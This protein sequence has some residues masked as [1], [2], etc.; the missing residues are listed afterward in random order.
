MKELAEKDKAVKETMDKERLAA[1]KAADIL[2]F[3]LFGFGEVLVFLI[4]FMGPHCLAHSLY[5]FTPCHFTVFRAKLIFSTNEMSSSKDNSF[6]YH[7]KWLVIPFNHTFNN[8]KLRKPFY[9][10][11]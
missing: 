9:R 4:G 11:P 2:N 5:Q 8:R 7:R 10:N 6:G 1:M 3:I